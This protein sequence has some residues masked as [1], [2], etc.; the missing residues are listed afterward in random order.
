[1]RLRESYRKTKI[2]V[3][4]ALLLVSCSMVFLQLGFK[5]FGEGAVNDYYLLAIIPVVVTSF[6]LGASWG[7]LQGILTGIA[8]SIHANIQPLD[9]ME[10]GLITPFTVVV[11]LALAGFGFGVVFSF[12]E[13]L[14]HTRLQNVFWIAL[15]C[16]VGTVLFDVVFSHALLVSLFDFSQEA[17]TLF[18]KISIVN[19]PLSLLWESLALFV[20]V[21][22]TDGL[23]KYVMI[24]GEGA[25]LH[26]VF[27]SRLFALLL[28]VFA[29]TASAGY[30]L[31][32]H[33]DI[34]E[35]SEEMNDQLEVIAA[36][37]EG[38]QSE[39]EYNEVART[40][41]YAIVGEKDGDLILLDNKGVV[42]ASNNAYDTEGA[43]LTDRDGYPLIEQVK[44]MALS[45]TMNLVYAKDV[46]EEGPGGS[47]EFSFMDHADGLDYAR[48][49]RAGDY[50][51]LQVRSHEMVFMD[52]SVAML[53]ATLIAGTVLV[54]VF[55]F[56]S[57]LL[58]STVEEPLDGANESLAKITSGDLNQKVW[59]R[60]S[61][62]LATLGAYINAAVASLKDYAAESERRIEQDL[63]TARDIQKSALPQT[64]PPFEEVDAFD[65]YAS[66]RAAKYVG[67]DFYD[68]F[69][70]GDHKLGFLIA[71]VSGKG[72][73]AALFMMRAKT[74]IAT[75]MR[76]GVDLVK[77]VTQTNA[78]LCEDN[79]TFMFVTMWAAIL[80]WE[81]GE[82][83]YVNAGHDI[84]LLRHND[85][86]QWFEDIGGP[87]LG[88]MDFVTYDCATV[89]M[90]HGDALY[91]YT[92]GVTEAMNRADQLYGKERMLAFLQAHADLRPHELDDAMREELVAW[93]DGAEQSD[94]I[95]MLTLAYK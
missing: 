6:L 56:A 34:L 92:D 9:W 31:I 24:P 55:V 26:V 11:P 94:D 90:G 73:P 15:S 32:T 23:L 65:V 19:D 46:K 38:Q 35:T 83:T 70:V 40:I 54:L 22:L 76:S 53:V 42:V 81:S 67:G 43:V 88:A 63:R 45:G 80:D 37:L 50:Y 64:F 3:F 5:S 20:S 78:Y 48:A 36:K 51:L 86:W 77:A 2:T 72:I 10:H 60:S 8:L 39:Q 71:D 49:V 74:H 28:V 79:D 68:L 27:G 7:A 75:A 16:A 95:T 21:E 13:R 91:L 93:A 44:S 57:K 30:A 69:R 89:S 87:F 52:R 25:R 85:Q 14:N 12:L 62:E 29:V 59:L 17:L 4:V 18:F 66:M 33:F 58:Y 82:L 1:M 41:L 84:P 47:T 61:R